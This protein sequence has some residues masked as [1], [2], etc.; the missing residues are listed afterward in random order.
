M[1]IKKRIVLL[2]V[3]SV[4]FFGA[5]GPGNNFRD[6]KGIKSQNPDLIENYNNLDRHANLGKVCIDGVAFL[7][8]TRQYDAVTRVPEWD[9]T[10][11]GFVG[12]QQGK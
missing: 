12:P 9:R 3:G 4:L 2:V 5:C 8:T 6:V 1:N 7:T 10:C 11:P